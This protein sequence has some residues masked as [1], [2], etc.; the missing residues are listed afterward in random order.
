MNLCEQ[1][2][3]KIETPG[4]TGIC[5]GCHCFNKLPRWYQKA[6]TYI[7]GPDGHANATKKPLTGDDMLDKTPFRP[8]MTKE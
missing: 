2:G 8:S 5:L 3:D 4:K 6:E 7:E 1:C